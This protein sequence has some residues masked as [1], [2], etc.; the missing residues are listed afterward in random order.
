MIYPP[1]TVFETEFFPERG[2]SFHNLRSILKSTLN[3]PTVAHAAKSFLD[4]E[5][6]NMTM[7]K[8]SEASVPNDDQPLDLSVKRVGNGGKRLTEDYKSGFKHVANRRSEIPCKKMRESRHHEEDDFHYLNHSVE[9]FCEQKLIIVDDQKGGG[10]EREDR[11]DRPSIADSL[12]LAREADLSNSDARSSSGE[13]DPNC[14]VQ[15]NGRL[16]RTVRCSQK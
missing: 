14:K 8:E 9:S 12:E 1:S 10:R 5:P 6:L 4:D 3:L 11:A 7:A 2:S 15:S 13:K 16:K